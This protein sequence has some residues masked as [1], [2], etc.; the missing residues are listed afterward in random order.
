MS[1]QEAEKLRE[2][3]HAQGKRLVFTSGCFDLLHAGHVRYLAQARAA[4]DALLVALNSD[5]SVRALKGESR[6]L[7]SQ[8]DRAEILCALRSVDAVVIFDEDRTTKLIQQ[9]KPHVFAKGG[10]YT[11]DSLNPEERAA[12][13]SVNTEIKILLLVPGRSTTKTVN[14]MLKPE[15]ESKLVLGVLGSGVGS[16]LDAILR[17][18]NLGELEAEIGVVISDVADSGVMK[19]AEKAGVPA[20]FVDPGPHPNKFGDAAQ[21]EVCEH[22]ERHRVDVV[23]LAGFMR[24]L[25][26]P[27]LSAYAGRIVNVHPSLLPL[28]KGRDA[29]QQAIDDGEIETGCTVHLVTADVDAGE[30]LAQAKVPIVIADTAKALHERIKEAEHKLLPQV[31]SEWRARGLP[32]QGGVVEKA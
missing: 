26:D 23:V 18:I 1:V 10:D 17:A 4:G 7:Q 6:P 29:P 8:E 2:E 13:E 32:T 9:I 22:L 16:N 25:K 30:I 15:G 31:L 24:L 14:K 12:L 19:L 5:A 21:K 28:F 20:V 11:V 3:L 27:V